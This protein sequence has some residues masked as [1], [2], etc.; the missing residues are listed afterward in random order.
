MKF[1]TLESIYLAGLSE[2]GL[3]KCETKEMGENELFY[4]GV[5]KWRCVGEF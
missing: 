5:L 1:L 2:V 3:L 4:T